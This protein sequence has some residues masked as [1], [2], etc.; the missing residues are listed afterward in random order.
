V[1]V[2]A[3][4]GRT[5]Q[6]DYS[7]AERTLDEAARLARSAADDHAL[8]FALTA[9]GRLRLLRGEHVAARTALDL[10]CS[11][12]QDLGWTSFLPF[13]RA[14]RAEVAL[15]L[16]DLAEAADGFDHS[17]ALACQVG[18]PCWESYSLRGRGLLAAERGDDALAL[19]LLTAAP[20]ACRRQR[21]A[22]DWVEGYCMEALC[23]FAVSR[24]VAGAAGWT[25]ELTEFASRRGMRELVARAAAHRAAL[26][27]V[28]A[29]ELAALL[30][31][32]IDNPV[33][34]KLVAHPA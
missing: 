15:V 33:L 18:D 32:G 34:G 4:I 8:A 2:Y 20:A 16:G 30:L 27:Q 19:D 23:R 3:G 17:Y 22:H 5:D 21:D 7:I 12:A 28:G 9:T 29:G 31:A 13:P 24:Q 25:R 1:G 26:G 6:A 10:A 14:L 11:T